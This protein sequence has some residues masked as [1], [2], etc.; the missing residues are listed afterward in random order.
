[1]ASLEDN[2]Q[3]DELRAFLTARKGVT[4][5]QPFGP[6]TAVFKVLGKL[7]AL[8]PD[9]EPLRISLKCDPDEALF[10]RDIYPAV[11]PGYHLNKRH[12]NTVT[13][14]GTVP[15]KE[16]RQMI[17]NSYDLVVKGLKKAERTRLQSL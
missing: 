2:M 15:D 9:N 13:V 3:R 1:M 12:W 14:D 8:V 11:Q 5:E 17:D 16:L 4:E 7:Y 10:L 6:D